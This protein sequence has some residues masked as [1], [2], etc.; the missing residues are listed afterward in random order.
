MSQPD[1]PDTRDIPEPRPD[2]KEVGARVMLVGGG[3]RSHALAEALRR[4]PSVA[5]VLL[6]PGTS[7]LERRGY[8]T[9]PVA[10]QDLLGLAE[11][12]ELEEIDLTVVGPNT[13]LV[14]GIVDIFQQRGLAIFGPDEDAAKLEGSKVFA[15]LLMNRLAIETPRFAICDTI[16]RAAHLA[17]TTTWARVFKAD[18]IAYGKG[19]RVTHHASECDDALNDVMHDNIFGLESKRIVVEERLD[20]TEVTVFSLTD[21]TDVCVLGHVLNY[22]RLH[23]DDAGPPTRGMG[24]LAPAPVIDSETYAHIHKDVLQPTVDAMADRGTPVRGAL[25]VDL[26]LVRGRALVIDYNVRFGDPATQILLS[27][28]SGDFYGALLA[29]LGDGQLTAAV[30]ALT[31]DERPRASVVLSAEGYPDKRVRGAQISVDEAHFAADD[32]LWLFEDGV[33][34]LPEPDTIETTGGRIMTVVAAADTYGRARE[35][36]YLAAEKVQFTGKHHRTDIGKGW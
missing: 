24:Q 31:F 17:T 27:R 25:F 8:R 22:P 15:R 26:M 13:P 36:A 30:D 3:A 16:A 5:T 34:W 20:G 33:R 2:A 1:A 7:G 23:D 21:G 28:I 4:S 6:A 10:S 12:A 19:V 9:L 11:M 18:G 32:D 14:D 35:K 29:C